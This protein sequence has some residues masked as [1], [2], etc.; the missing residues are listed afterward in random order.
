MNVS[1]NLSF[2]IL[3]LIYISLLNIIFLK[4]EHIK[5]FEISIFRKLILLNL[6]GIILEFG[7]IYSILFS[8]VPIVVQI[9]NKL[10]LIY[11]VTFVFMF[12]LYVFSISFSNDKGKLK[13][14][15]KIIL[16]VYLVMV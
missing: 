8:K 1:I 16:P 4:K 9:I 13:K 10:F 12:S 11:L 14:I 7:C 3:S 6:F 2:L 15:T 5:T